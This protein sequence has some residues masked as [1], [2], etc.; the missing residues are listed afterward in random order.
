MTTKIIGNITND[1]YKVP[2]H[3]KKSDWFCTQS[4]VSMLWKSFWMRGRIKISPSSIQIIYPI[5]L[6]LIYKIRSGSF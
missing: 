5:N 2:W 1:H 3:E 6:V 4:L